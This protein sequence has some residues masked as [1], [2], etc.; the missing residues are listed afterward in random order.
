[1]GKFYVTTPIYYVNSNPHV[2][3]AYTTIA[4]DVLKRSARLENKDTFLVTGSDENSLKNVKAAQ[5]AGQ[6]TQEFINK[7]SYVWADTWNQ[8]NI[9]YDFFIRTSDVRHVDGVVKFWEKV[10]ASGDL[11]KGTYEG[12]Y[13]APC[14]AFLST[15][16]LNENGKCPTH[17]RKPDE[18]KEGNYFFKASKYKQQILNHIASNPDFIQPISRHNEIIAYI[19]NHFEDVSVSRQALEWGIPVPDEPDQVIYVWFDALINYLTAVGYGWNT[20]IFAKWWPADLHLVGKDIIK[21]HCALWPAMLLSAGLPLPRQIWAHGFFTVDGQK[22]SKTLKNTVD[23][24]Q[25]AETYTHEG[26]RYYLLGKLPFGS[27]G[28]FSFEN[29]QH[30][31]DADLANTIGNLASR[32]SGMIN[33]YF[34]GHLPSAPEYINNSASELAE[35]VKNIRNLTAQLHFKEALSEILS[36]ARGCNKEIEDLKPWQLA[37]NKDY[38]TL[39]RFLFTLAYRLVYIGYAI[40]PYLPETGKKLAKTFSSPQ[41]KKLSPLFPKKVR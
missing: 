26:L 15:A 30:A 23:P 10:K 12:L 17:L 9:D 29:L 7:L 36:R 38:T 18:V 35:W 25:I 32:V 8:L 28:D 13:C 16:D 33:K 27:D 20:D 5:E 22:I 41:V 4:A 11:Y 37:K 24:L 2:G 1:M 3:H 19:E 14:E 40:N 34:G 6:P 39:G 21:F 31:Y